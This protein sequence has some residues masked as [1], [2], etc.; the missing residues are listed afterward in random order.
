MI[1]M[2]AQLL[3]NEIEEA[4][5][6]SGVAIDDVCEEVGV[7]RATWQRWKAGDFDPRLSTFQRLIAVHDKY[8]TI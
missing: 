6:S 7:N 8:V 4:A 5:R 3:V 1:R 2:N